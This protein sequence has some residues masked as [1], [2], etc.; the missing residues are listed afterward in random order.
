MLT[1]EDAGHVIPM[2]QPELY[3]QAVI[4]FLLEQPLPQAPYTGDEAPW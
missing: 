3:R 1:V 2:D 4:A